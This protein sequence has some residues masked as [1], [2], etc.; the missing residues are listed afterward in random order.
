V[1]SFTIKLKE[2]NI[3]K[4]GIELD[5]DPNPLEIKPGEIKFVS[6][7]VTN[8]GEI[9]DNFT[10][11]INDANFTKLNAEV[12]KQDTCEIEPGKNKE[13]LIMVNINE[14]TG[15]GFVNINV[16]AKSLLAEKY[17]VDIQDSQL[18]TIKILEKD[19]QKEKEQGQPI[20]IFYFSIL[21]FIII[22]II[23]S[24]II[25]IIVRKKASK[26]DSEVVESQEIIP[27]TPPES[28][29]T[30]EPEIA[31]EPIPVSDIQQEDTFE[32]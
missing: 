32:E 2:D 15:P 17:N 3:P 14:G 8:L 24:I 23:I 26:K 5:L 4:F 10:I 27:E 19:D 16:T 12:Y 13:F 25:L 31:A 28:I 9:T 20:S 30:P 6:V 21:L 11:T 18:L 29:T 1:W 7:I 22:L